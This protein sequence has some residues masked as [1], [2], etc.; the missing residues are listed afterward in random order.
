MRDHR[1]YPNEKN[2]LNSRKWKTTRMR[3][4]FSSVALATLM[5]FS[6]PASADLDGVWSESAGGLN[7]YGKPIRTPD[8]FNLRLL[9][10]DGLLCGT[11]EASGHYG[12]KIDFSR[13]FGRQTA[14]LASL[15]FLNGFTGDHTSFGVA[16]MKASGRRGK[17]VVTKKPIG[18]SWVWRTANV[19]KRKLSAKE[20]TDLEKTC[21]PH[22]DRLANIDFTNDAETLEFLGTA[23]Q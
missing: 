20:R 15:Y 5:L 22:W 16:T 12:G 18:E 7:E 13:I 17:W 21:S 1:I 3:V 8:F 9:S 10:H 4:A 11:Y 2:E 19:K 14:N 6:L 23:S